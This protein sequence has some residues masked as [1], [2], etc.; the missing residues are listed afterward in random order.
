MKFVLAFVPTTPL[1]AAFAVG[2]LI[3]V[4]SKILAPLVRIT[5]ALV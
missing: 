2:A 4:A 1:D 5:A 3:V